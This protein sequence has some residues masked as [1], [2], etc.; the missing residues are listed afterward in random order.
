[1]MKTVNRMILTAAAASMAVLPV[2]AQ[3]N[4]RAGD[5]GAIYSTS[6]P[7]LGRDAEGEDLKGGGVSIILALLA[8]AAVIGGIIYATDSDGDGQSPGA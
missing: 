1:M 4:T 5:S 2:A 3:A 7:G 8:A 6:G